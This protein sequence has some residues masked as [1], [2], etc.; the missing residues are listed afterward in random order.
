M[1]FF[2]YHASVAKSPVFINSRE[3]TSRF[4][5]PPGDYVLVPS[6]FD[7]NEEGEFIL[8]VFTEKKNEMEYVFLIFSM[9]F[10]TECIYLFISMAHLN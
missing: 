2:K 10:C 6:T 7:P 1:N 3:V 4:K 9:F 8:R 5:L